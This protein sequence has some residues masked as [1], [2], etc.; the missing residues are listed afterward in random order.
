VFLLLLNYHT[1]CSLSPL[2]RIQN[3]FFPFQVWVS[4][5][6]RIQETI[7]GWLKPNGGTVYALSQEE[8]PSS[9]PIAAVFR[10]P[11]L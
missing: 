8:M 2:S 6:Y 10:Y 11:V 4:L 5:T 3:G 7:K 1:F 9:S